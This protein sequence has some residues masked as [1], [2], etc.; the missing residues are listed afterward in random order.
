[1]ERK[2]ILLS[3]YPYPV[4]FGISGL[5]HNLDSSLVDKRSGIEVGFNANITSYL[6][7]ESLSHLDW[8]LSQVIRFDIIKNRG[9]LG[10]SKDGKFFLDFGYFPDNFFDK[11]RISGIDF[12]RWNIGDSVEIPAS[13]LL[14][15]LGYYDDDLM[16]SH[17]Y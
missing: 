8:Y 2:N 3:E 16:L 4:R 6:D 1:M 10:L 7:F 9:L 5:F 15:T 13:I 11:L 14:E 12:M 17:L